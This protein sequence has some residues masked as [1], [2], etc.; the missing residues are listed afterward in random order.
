MGN[1]D[2]EH[3]NDVIE[4]LSYFHEL[5]FKIDNVLYVLQPENK[6]LVLYSMN[7]D[8]DY[9]DRVPYPPEAKSIDIEIIKG[10]LNKKYF[11]GFSFMERLDDVLIVDLQ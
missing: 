4:Y 6:H 5:V 8:A 9:L 2:L 1:I 10:I 11:N 7:P 3:L